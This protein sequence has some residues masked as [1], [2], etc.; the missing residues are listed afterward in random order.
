MHFTDH[1][2]VN[3]NGA[4]LATLC[5]TPLGHANGHVGVLDATVRI[6]KEACPKC[7]ELLPAARGEVA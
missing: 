7:L 6:S 3:P 2:L 5:G 4:G 1:A